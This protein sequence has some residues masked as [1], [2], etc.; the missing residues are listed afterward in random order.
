MPGSEFTSSTNPF[1]HKLLA[2]TGLPLQT[3]GP[4]Q[5]LHA[6]HFLFFFSLIFLLRFHVVQYD[7]HYQLIYTLVH[8]GLV[9]SHIMQCE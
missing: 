5:I 6:N 7:G 1:H 3:P 2:P 8:C 9:S 4:F